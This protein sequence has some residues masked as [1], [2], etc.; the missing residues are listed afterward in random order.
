MSEPS[1]SDP[2]LDPAEAEAALARLVREFYGKARQDPALGP[3]FNNAVVDWDVHYHTVTNFWSHA[4]L[5]TTRYKG[6]PYAPHVHLPIQPEHFDRW[7]SL[8]EETARETLPSP[9][10]ERAIEKAQHVARGFK[11]GL[12][13]FTDANGNPSRHPRQ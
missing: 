5:G 9:L 13:P 1:S 10:A 7:L 8:F 6:T 2:S 12:F 4:L 11:V 3:I